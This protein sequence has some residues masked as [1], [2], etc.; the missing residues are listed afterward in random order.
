MCDPY[1][2]M[3]V[4]HLHCKRLEQELGTTTMRDV[5]AV[6]VELHARQSTDAETVLVIKEQDVCHR[7]VLGSE[8][9]KDARREDLIRYKWWTH[10]DWIL[11]N[12]QASNDENEL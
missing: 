8:I 5:Y 4:A 2:I 12:Q 1:V 11:P 7:F 3:H 9:P 10:N 6:D